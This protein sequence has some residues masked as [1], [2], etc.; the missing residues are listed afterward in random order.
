MSPSK[1][2][3]SLALLTVGMVIPNIIVAQSATSTQTQEVNVNSSTEIKSKNIDLAPQ[4]VE[5]EKAHVIGDDGQ[6]IYFMADPSTTTNNEKTAA[7]KPAATPVNKSK[8]VTPAL[9]PE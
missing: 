5:V 1:I 9:K 2:I 4:S 7:E 6:K 8:E 3:F